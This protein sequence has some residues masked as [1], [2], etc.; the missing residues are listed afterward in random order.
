MSFDLK[1]DLHLHTTAS[2]GTWGPEKLVQNIRNTGIGL[3]AVTDHDSTENLADTAR[4]AKEHGLEFINGVEINTTYNGRNYHIL[5]LGIDPANTKVQRILAMNKKLLE[6]K[7]DDFIKYLE[8]EYPAVSFSEYESYI[9]HKERGG[10]K[11]LNYLMD[12]RLCN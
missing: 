2:D 5:G 12:K 1:T 7:D 11:A 4:L 9:N 8:T 10:W 6:E 3:F